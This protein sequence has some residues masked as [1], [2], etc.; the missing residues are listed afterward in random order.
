M[1]SLIMVSSLQLLFILNHMISWW[2]G[3]VSGEHT[4]M[5]KKTPGSRC[6]SGGMTTD[7]QW[8]CDESVIEC[9]NFR[10]FS[11][12]NETFEKPFPKKLLELEGLSQF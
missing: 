3:V 7:M 9:A 6:R 10:F 11:T 5:H 2:V 4:Y 8:F 12:G 1:A